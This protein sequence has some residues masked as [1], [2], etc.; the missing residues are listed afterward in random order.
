MP[1]DRCL[2]PRPCSR[3]GAPLTADSES[4]RRPFPVRTAE[5]SRRRASGGDWTSRNKHARSGRREDIFGRRGGRR[6][7]CWVQ[8]RSARPG[9]AAPSL[10]ESVSD[11]SL[12]ESV[13]PLGP[14][15]DA[16]RGRAARHPSPTGAAASNRGPG[17]ASLP[18][19]VCVCEVRVRE[20]CARVACVC[21]R[22]GAEPRKHLP[23]GPRRAARSPAKQ[24]QP[25]ARASAI[26]NVPSD[27]AEGAERSFG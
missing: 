19:G 12:S 25:G 22:P 5:A 17:S 27:S 7:L 8:C 6:L 13:S 15:L 14:R 1:R 11:Q 23:P 24:P 9:R 21:A 20:A 26:L 16:Q 4:R 10:S 2:R 18:S 3:R